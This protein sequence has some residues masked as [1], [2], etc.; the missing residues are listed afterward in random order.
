M[1]SKQ[2]ELVFANMDMQVWLVLSPFL[3][4]SLATT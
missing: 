4:A 3:F 1:K 2:M